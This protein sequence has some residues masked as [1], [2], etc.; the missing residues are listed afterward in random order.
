MRP[1]LACILV[2]LATS[3]AARADDG[4]DR[5]AWP[6]MRERAA[7]TAPNLPMVPPGSTMDA[8]CFSALLPPDQVSYVMPP[9]RRPRIENWRGGI[10]QLPSPP[11]AGVYQL[12]LSDE[13]RSVGS[14][15]RSDCPG[16]R[17]SVRFE[18]AASP[19]WCR[20][21]ASPAIDFACFRRGGPAGR[22]NPA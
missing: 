10:V 22:L 19:S 7:L 18:L 5:F 8:N 13:V 20:S 6:V 21:A 15:G 3:A 9:K 14:R 11:R 12:T 17:K 16:L 4:C 1:Q 2:L